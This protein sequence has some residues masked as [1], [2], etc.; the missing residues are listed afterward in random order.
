MSATNLHII[1]HTTTT[2]HTRALLDVFVLLHFQIACSGASHVKH[3]TSHVTSRTSHVTRRTSHVTRRTSHGTRHTSHVTRHTSHVTR[4]RRV[5]SRA[6]LPLTDAVRLALCIVSE[7]HQ[8]SHVTYYTMQQLAAKINSQ[9]VC[10]KVD[11]DSYFSTFLHV[12]L[13]DC[14]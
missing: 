9:T 11:C 13:G 6:P 12:C 14:S 4:D 2:P 5:A 7:S 1:S 3:H 10:S 8:T